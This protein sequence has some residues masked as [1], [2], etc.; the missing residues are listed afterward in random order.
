MKKTVLPFLMILFA[1]SLSLNLLAQVPPPEGFPE[2]TVVENGETGDGLVFLCTSAEAED[3]FVFTLNNA[4]EL[5]S[6]R[7]LQ[8]DYAYDFKMQPNGLLSYG[9]FISHHSYTGGGN[10]IHMVMDQEMNLVDSIQLRNEYI[11][12]AHDFQILPNG[13]I[14]MFGYYL[15]QM[16]LSEIVD[17]GYPDARVSGGIVQELDAEGNVIFQWR[18]WDHYTPENYPSWTRANR[19]TVSAFHLNTIN[20]DIDGNLILA[21]PSFTKKLNRQTSEIMWHLGGDENEF[22]FVGVDST[23][24]VGYVTG[25]AFYRLENGNFLLYDNSAR[26]GTS[27]PNSEVHEFY[28]DEENKIAELVWTY[29]Y[30]EDI[31]GWHR[32]NAQRLPNGNTMIGWGG[33]SGDP[34]PTATEV[35]M[36]G[37][38]MWEAYFTNA[39]MESYRAF[40]FPMGDALAA[41]Q[42]LVELIQGNTYEF[43]QGDT[44]DTGIDVFL[45]TITGSGYNELTVSTYNQAPKY[46]TFEGEDPMLLTKRVTLLPAYMYFSGTIYCE[47]DVLGIENPEEITIYYRDVEDEGQFEPLATSWNYVTGKLEADF[48]METAAKCEF[49]FGYPDHEP[50]AFPAWLHT[51]ADGVSVNHEET[52]R[53]EWSPNGFFKYFTLQIA[54]DESFSNIVVEETNY[55]QTYYY[56]EP[57][58]NTSYFWRVKS[59]TES[60]NSFIAADWSE[61][62]TFNGTGPQLDIEVPAGNEAWTHGL[63]HFIEW[64]DNFADDVV[65]ELYREDTLMYVIDTVESD[66]AYLWEIPVEQEIGCKYKVSVKNV[67]NNAIVS[68]SPDYFSI[69][70]T[71]GNDGCEDGVE[72]KYLIQQFKVYPVPS[73]DFVFLE[74]YLSDQET[75]SMT[76]LDLHGHEIKVFAE[77]RKTIGYHKQEIS[78]GDLPKGIYLIMVNA[79]SQAY[80]EKLIIH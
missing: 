51:P 77:E 41:E 25:H 15:T 32:G 36:E 31:G 69:T 67:V 2:I 21:T 18:T 64:N 10:V 16:D 27:N 57:E 38:I 54:T 55:Y 48:E 60:G 74:Y 29:A 75:I 72:E 46:P 44:L 53:M 49:V 58:D 1:F 23:N 65:L 13:H 22:S 28:I 78:V 17:G 45:E 39:A 5:M 61:T 40:R 47:A 3:Y 35:D 68:M 11:A 8:D 26:Q 63:E 7:E 30:P 50:I 52:L 4:G 9:Q 20:L 6:Y 12:E 37:N 24:G 14:L 80:F 33:A 79:G 70:D 43:I 34:I 56:F 62:F 71:A 73:N 42:L 19:Q 76:L 59:F 66:G